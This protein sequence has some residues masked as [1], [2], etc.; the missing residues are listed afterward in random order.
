MGLEGAIIGHQR[1]IHHYPSFHISSV[2]LER[3]LESCIVPVAD[4]FETL[5]P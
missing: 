2:S 4:N 3:T 5:G 1:I